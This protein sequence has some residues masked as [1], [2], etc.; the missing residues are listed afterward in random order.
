[1]LQTPI[2]MTGHSKNRAATPFKGED[3]QVPPREPHLIRGSADYED[4]LDRLSKGV[5]V[6]RDAQHG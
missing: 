1:L 2:V 5:T 3:R 6:L 4:M